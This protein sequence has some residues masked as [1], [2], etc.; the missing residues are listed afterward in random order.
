MGYIAPEVLSRNFANVPHK[1]DVYSFG[2]LLIEMIGGK[3]NNDVVVE[4]DSQIYF[5]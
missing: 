4:N 1:S 3:K 2:V 5:P